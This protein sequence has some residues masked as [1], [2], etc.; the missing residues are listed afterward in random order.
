MARPALTSR[1]PSSLTDPR[2]L[3]A[4]LAG[5]LN[6]AV[7]TLTITVAAATLVFAP[8]GA[9]AFPQA[10][11]A[12]LV[13]VVVGGMVAGL[14][15]STPVSMSSPR[16]AVS[17]VVASLVGVL[18]RDFPSL[19]PITVILLACVT[20][21]L[22]GALQAIAGTLRLG[23]LVRF[24]PFPVIAGF[25]HGI[26]LAL[27]AI[28][29]PVMLGMA[30][31]PRLAW[32]SGAPVQWGAVAVGLFTIAVTWGCVH[33]KLR[34]PALFVGLVSGTLLHVVL[35]AEVP[36]LATGAVLPIGKLAFPGAL[37]GDATVMQQL[38]QPAI[39]RLLVSF[40]IAIAVVASVDSLI[41]AMAVETRT[42]VRSNPNRDLAAQ[43]LANMA[44]GAAGG[45]AISYAA[46]QVLSAVGA[47][48]RDR[49]ASVASPLVV[50]A[51]AAAGAGLIDGIP[52][53]VVAALMIYVAV[54]LADPWGFALLRLALDPATRR[55]PT[56][57]DS[58]VVYALVTLAIVLLDVVTALVVGVTVAAII[59]L[60]NVNQHVVRR[61]LSGPAIRSRRLFPPGPTQ[62]LSKGM[63]SVAVV[64]LQGPLFFGTADRIV[65]EV[66]QLPSATRFVIVDLWRVQALDE[67]AVAVL[68]R[69]AS[70]LRAQRR[71]LLVSGR[72][73]GL[74][75][76]DGSMP[77]V[78]ADRDRA[79]E[80]VEERLLDEAGMPTVPPHI[81]A[82]EV[83]RLL[84]LH[85]EEA[86][87]LVREARVEE[88]P[89]GHRIFRA[90]DASDELYFLLSGR[91]S[92]VHEGGGTPMRIVTFLPG[93]MFGDVAFVDRQPRSADAMCDV[94]SRVLVLDRAALARIEGQQPAVVT[95]LYA[96]LS[97]NIAARL[98]ATDRLVRE[99]V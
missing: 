42:G 23:Q 32:P 21:L 61:V 66:Q 43:G 36:S 1:P 67:T 79:L 78:F 41:G 25:T 11:A 14:V 75:A 68:S 73:P 54:R 12:C 90:G 86:Q 10:L 4:N 3:G 52:M 59:F 29:I 18:H 27:L 96:M 19:A 35:G 38:S 85:G 9:A 55:D 57:R 84:D 74:L 89:A 53:A 60:R 92:I 40:A 94:S 48:A 95:R 2:R 65:E 37:L 46:V 87:L 31:L 72:P 44:S 82:D 88:L 33:L 91:V 26:A 81:D 64:E 69:L 63:D 7:S 50:G 39:W 98:R 70:R 28:Y 8:L 45:V 80:W 58:L 6:G 22:A 49:I 34:L 20:V 99:V 15:S 71:E 5:T 51:L 62:V 24:V 83:T 93:N 13:C 56:V 16:A 17:I 47:G 97:H 30:E 76:I 77:Q